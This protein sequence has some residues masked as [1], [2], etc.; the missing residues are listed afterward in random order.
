MSDTPLLQL[1]STSGGIVIAATHTPLGLDAPR[2]LKLGRAAV[3]A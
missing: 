2:E 3:A 1:L